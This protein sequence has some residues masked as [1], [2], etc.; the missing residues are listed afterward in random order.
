MG[1][2]NVYDHRVVEG[3]TFCD[4]KAVEELII[5]DQKQRKG[6]MSAIHLFTI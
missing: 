4:P 5:C 2:L 1:G 3:L 6:Y